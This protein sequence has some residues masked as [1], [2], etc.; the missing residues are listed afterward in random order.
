MVTNIIIA[1]VGLL[2]GICGGYILRKYLAEA[3]ISSAEEQ[4]LKILKEAEEKNES[5]KKEKII[6][7]KDEVHRLRN[8][9]EK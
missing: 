7:A 6:E 5:L 3:K 1:I 9:L 2:L 8:E 4:A